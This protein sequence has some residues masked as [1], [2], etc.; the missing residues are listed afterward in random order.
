MEFWSAPSKV[1]LAPVEVDLRGLIDYRWRKRL[2]FPTSLSWI[3]SRSATNGP[4]PLF[5]HKPLEARSWAQKYFPKYHEKTIW[6]KNNIIPHD[7]S[8]TLHILRKTRRKIR[9]GWKNIARHHHYDTKCQGWKS[10]HQ[11]RRGQGMPTGDG[12]SQSR[13]AAIVLLLQDGR[14]CHLPKVRSNSGCKGQPL[15]NSKLSPA[16]LQGFIFL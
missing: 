5:F 1:V 13:T 2:S 3:R 11:M 4:R 15:C 8:G 7:M 12:S 10:S 16:L 6:L 14:R 9:Q